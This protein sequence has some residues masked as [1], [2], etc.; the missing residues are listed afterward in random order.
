M[1][2]YVCV[3]VSR[4]NTLFVVYGRLCVRRGGEVRWG[5]DG[6]PLHSLL[7]CVRS[8]FFFPLSLF[9]SFSHLSFHTCPCHFFLPSHLPL[10]PSLFSAPTRWQHGAAVAEQEKEKG[11]VERGGE[12]RWRSG[13]WRAWLRGP[14]R[15]SVFVR[16]VVRWIR[17]GAEGG[18]NRNPLRRRFA[19]NRQRTG[20]TAGL[21]RS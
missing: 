20:E 11:V 3:C 1:P 2:G 13:I 16:A 15:G 21:I 6:Q 18:Y 14:L 17:E 9:I 19:S 12:R 5:A 10:F 8:Y 7:Y 4:L